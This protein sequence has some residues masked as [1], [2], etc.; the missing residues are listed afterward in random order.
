LKDV[1]PLVIVDLA[2]PRD[3]DPAA[4]ELDS[5]ELRD[6]DDLRSVV[7]KGTEARKAELP[8]V[9]EIVES[10]VENVS[11]W[12]R[13]LALGPAIEALRTWAEAIRRAEVERLAKT[14][15]AEALDRATK[16]LMNKLLHQPM[17]RMRELVR[18]KDGQF[19]LEAFQEIFDLDTE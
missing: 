5:V 15:D 8:K 7:E 11:A 12:E 3:I 14:G 6:I 2:V 9:A 17:V 18:D 19:Y 16:A 10:E 4:R 1:R 13:S